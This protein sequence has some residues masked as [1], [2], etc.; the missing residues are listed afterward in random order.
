MTA[1]STRHVVEI[2]LLALIASAAVFAKIPVL[3]RIEL[4]AVFVVDLFWITWVVNAP[5]R[6]P[7]AKN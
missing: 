3:L 2:A 4:I 5:L 1:V 7:R 6:K